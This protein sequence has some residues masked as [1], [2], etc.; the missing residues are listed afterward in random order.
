MLAMAQLGSCTLPRGLLENLDG[1]EDTVGRN[2]SLAGFG[3][4]AGLM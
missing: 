4:K 1:Q 3:S 2:G